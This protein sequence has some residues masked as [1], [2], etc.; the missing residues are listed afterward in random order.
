ML[1]APSLLCPHRRDAEA[2]IS[3][4]HKWPIFLAVSADNKRRTRVHIRTIGATHFPS[5][6]SSPSPDVQM[7][8]FMLLVVKAST[9]LLEMVAS[10]VPSPGS[11]V[12]V[13]S[14]K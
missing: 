9:P 14:Y 3:L 5:A 7:Q 4:S 11:E 8:A 2:D 10:N 6:V 13:S 1:G 12:D